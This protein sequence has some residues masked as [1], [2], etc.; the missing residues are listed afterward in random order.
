MVA[1][2]EQTSSTL[3]HMMINSMHDRAKAAA[4]YDRAGSLQYEHDTVQPLRSVSVLGSNKCYRI[5]RY[6]GCG[7]H[8]V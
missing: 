6:T 4:S 7:I 3:Q 5:L 8:L 1:R 2:L